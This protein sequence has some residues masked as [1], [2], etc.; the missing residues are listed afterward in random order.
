M[1]PSIRLLV[2]TA[3]TWKGTGDPTAWASADNPHVE[4]VT[5]W[6]VMPGDLD[7]FGHMNNSRHLM[8]MDFARLDYLARM[9]MMSA[10]LG[11][12]WSVPVAMA[13]V[14]F[15][16]ALKPFERFGIGAQVLSWNHRWFYPRQT[17]RTAQCLNRIV[18]TAYVKTIFCSPSGQVALKDVVRMAVGHDLPSPT[19]PE[20]VRVKFGLAGPRAD[21]SAAVVGPHSRALVEMSHEPVLHTPGRLIEEPAEGLRA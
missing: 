12:R 6:R 9:G 1:K 15:Y 18:A 3:A 7:L 4:T 16:R 2:L 17:F 11:R 21:I 13:Q 14:G 8:L 20:H 10:A 5:R 19:M